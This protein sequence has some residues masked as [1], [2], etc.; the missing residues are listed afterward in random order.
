LGKPCVSRGGGVKE[1]KNS[2]TSEK[3]NSGKVRELTGLTK[4]VS[5]I[6]AKMIQR[7]ASPMEGEKK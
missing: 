2:R 1:L 5:P 4:A 6:E 3:N 7:L